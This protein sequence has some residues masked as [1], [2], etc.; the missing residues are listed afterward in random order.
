MTIRAPI[1]TNCSLERAASCK[2]H[3]DDRYAVGVAWTDLWS[4]SKNLQPQPHYQPLAPIAASDGVKPV[5]F[6]TPG[7]IVTSAM[8]KAPPER[9]KELLRIVD[10]L[11]APFGSAEELLLSY[12]VAGTDYHLDD[13]GNPIATER[14]N[15]DALGPSWRYIVQRQQVMS[16]PSWPDYARIGYEFE[17]AAVPAGIDDPTW[18]LYSPA[19]SKSGPVLNKTL[20][21]GF[22]GI[23]LGQRPLA[24]YDQLVADWQSGGG[25]TIRTELQQAV[26]AAA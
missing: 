3:G 15:A 13:N 22:K 2:P 24:D 23:V 19:Q 9:I 26:A 8:K 5:H 14:S 10:W 16:Y 4:I 17:H 20:L 21:D 18:G 12:G 1:P 11:A 7:F 6:L 25:N